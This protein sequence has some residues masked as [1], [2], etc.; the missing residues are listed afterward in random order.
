MEVMRHVR[1]YK[2]ARQALAALGAD[3]EVLNQYK[4]IEKRDLK[5]SSDMLEENRVG[6]RNDALA[7]F[8]R[9]GTAQ[10]AGD[11]W[12]EEC[13]SVNTGRC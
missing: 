6:Q 2:R 1:S 9:L 3:D 5:M 12:M 10:T 4:D 13:K 11:G 8:W 7:W